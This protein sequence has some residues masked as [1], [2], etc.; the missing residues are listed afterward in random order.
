MK[1]II[2]QSM[3]RDPFFIPVFYYNEHHC[4][5]LSGCGSHSCAAFWHALNT[6][7][8]VLASVDPFGDTLDI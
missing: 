6:S 8:A 2:P 7:E 5:D 1:A 4:S 3:E